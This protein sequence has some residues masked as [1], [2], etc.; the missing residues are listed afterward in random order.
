MAKHADNPYDRVQATGTR[1]ASIIDLVAVGFARSLPDAQKGEPVAREVLKR[2]DRLAGLADLGIQDMSDL[3]GLDRFEIIRVKALIELGRRTA[4][5]NRGEVIGIEL[6]EDV[7]HRLDYLREEKRE[8]FVVI[9]LDSK[10]QIQRIA[11][12]HIGTVN[13]TIVGAREVF[14]EAIRDGA[15]SII[16]AHNHPSGDPTPSPEDIEVT[17]KLVEVGKLLDIPVIDH[18]IIGF[19][20]FTSFAKKGLI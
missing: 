2:H 8:H 19:D 20:R 16:V 9:T 1:S 13:M 15:S 10:N 14:R 11:P 6:P 18:I 12:V 4:Q 5:A 3:T 17:G 7:F